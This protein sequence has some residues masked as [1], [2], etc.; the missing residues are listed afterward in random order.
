MNWGSARTLPFRKE[1]VSSL[2]RP[3]SGLAIV[4]ELSLSG[5][6]GKR[7]AGSALVK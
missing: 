6:V 7:G 1:R 5:A 4:K 2:P 3:V